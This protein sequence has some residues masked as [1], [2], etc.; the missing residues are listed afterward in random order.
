MVRQIHSPRSICGA[1]GWSRSAAALLKALDLE[2][3]THNF[4]LRHQ[5]F[6]FC[7]VDGN[8]AIK[9]GVYTL[10]RKYKVRED[11]GL[12]F[13]SQKLF[14][15]RGCTPLEKVRS[16]ALESQK[17]ARRSSTSG[18]RVRSVWN[19]RGGDNLKMSVNVFSI[20]QR[21]SGWMALFLL[22]HV[23]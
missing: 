17:R 14:A 12:A 18:G 9:R 7:H 21:R 23:L 11:S 15:Y 1:L 13:A 16:S 6:S 4:F 2:I 3:P 5:K 20:F 10:G 8:G 22:F 19:K